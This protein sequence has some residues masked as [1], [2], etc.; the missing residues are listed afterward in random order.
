MTYMSNDNPDHNKLNKEP[1]NSLV[2]TGG[3]VTLPFD[4]EQFKDFVIGLLGKPQTIEQRIYGKFEVKLQDIQS[5]HYLIDQRLTQQNKALL[6]QFRA[7]IRFSDNSSITLNSFEDLATYNEVRPLISERVDLSWDYLI[8]FND[9][10]H[11][12]KQSIDIN[13]VTNREKIL[14][15]LGTGESSFF[16]ITIKHTARTWGMDIES[17]LTSHIKSLLDSEERIKKFIRQYNGWI[18]LFSGI[19]FFFGSVVGALWSTNLF[20]KK[21][22]ERINASINLSNEISD[23]ISIVAQYIASSDAS[24]QYLFV[25]IFLFFTFILS[26]VVG[27]VISSMADNE[28]LSFVLLTQSSFKNRLKK[29]KQSKDKWKAFIISFIVSLI[30]NIIASYIFMYLTEK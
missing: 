1:E 23:K 3:Y 15:F 17:L 19:L 20:I 24:R 2:T 5:F 9:K 18:G 12:E 7:K 11:P 30:T 27:I 8:Q 29:I 10:T 25:G 6:I 22:V 13:I 28:E 26:I 14:A 16:E 4:Q 21:Q